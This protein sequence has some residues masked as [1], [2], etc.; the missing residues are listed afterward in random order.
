M[1]D[2]DSEL[3][4]MASIVGILGSLEGD[5]RSR[6]LRYAMERFGLNEPIRGSNIVHDAAVTSEP[7]AAASFEDFASL[8]D[9]ANPIT[10]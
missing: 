10:G 4:A 9:A 7:S 3:S 6:V 2:Q 5:S 8:F 1:A